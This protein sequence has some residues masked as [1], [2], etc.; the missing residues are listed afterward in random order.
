MATNTQ[1]N[2]NLTAVILAGG[3]ARRM[4]GQ[5]KGLIELNG[6]AMIEYVI[7]ALIPQ[8]DNIVINANR[9]LE[10]Y[11]RYGYPVIKD[12]MGDY[13]G[14]LAGMASGLQAC[15]S[16]RI[17]IAPCDSPFLPSVLASRLNT[18]MTENQ[19]DISVA[20]DGERLQQAFAIIR[21][22]ILPSLLAYLND[23]GRKVETWYAKH[24]TALTDFSDLPVTFININ[25]P[26]DKEA[27]EKKLSNPDYYSQHGR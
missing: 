1:D 24:Q 12:I 8:V 13:P 9:N 6:R 17:L 25:T 18:A 19:A 2:Q 15:D 22:S 27:V 23:G 16:D 7:E 20:H 11:E 3:L 26:Q 21:R 4:D 5:D 10:Q 14:P